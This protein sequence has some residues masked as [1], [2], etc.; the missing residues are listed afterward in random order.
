L[1]DAV[2]LHPRE[3]RFYELDIL[4]GLA[5]ITVVFFHYK[6][7]LLI[8]DTI[9]FDY[10]HMPFSAILMPFYL[11]GQ[12]FVELFFAISGYVF[13]WLYA[14]PI[15]VGRTDAW[16]FFVARFARLYPLYFLTLIIVAVLQIAYRSQYGDDFI[17]NEDTG[18]N[19]VLNL[20]MVQ[21]WL[22][23]AVQS[24]NGPAW[25]I[26]VEV[27]LYTLFFLLCVWRQ[28]NIWVLGGLF[29]IGAV[30][31]V[32]SDPTVDFVRGVPSFFEGGLVFYAVRALR[33]TENTIWRKRIML[34][35]CGVLPLLWVVSYARGFHPINVLVE[36]GLFAAVFSVVGF[37]YVVMP[38]SLLALGLMQDHWRA[39]WLSRENLH[40]I[41]W[42]GDISYSIYLIHFPLQLGLML[43]LARLPFAE[44]AVIFSSP[45]ALLAFMALAAGLG[46]LSFRYFE[47]PMRRYLTRRMRPLLA[48]SP[49]VR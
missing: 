23:Y 28:N 45:L 31:R 20:L 2:P 22:P 39:P 25:S 8:S 38:L 24:F 48:P 9:G 43:V 10:G 21:Q 34:A 19:F 29:I 12:F 6:H 46:W 11:Y 1:S 26:S 27:F 3:A 7:F 33:R 4:R 44:R 36:P 17:Y 37:L 14:R 49:G 42:I 13:F 32:L 35:L 5:A 41:S 16:S 40:K 30:V 47:M 15:E 18:A